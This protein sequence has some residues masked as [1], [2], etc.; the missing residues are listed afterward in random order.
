MRRL[1]GTRYRR[2]QIKH[3]TRTR[4]SITQYILTQWS[5]HP[6]SQNAK[7][8]KST[9]HNIT[10]ID[11]YAWLRD[12]DW[13]N[14]MQN[15]SALCANIRAYLEQENAYTKAFMQ[16]TETLQEELFEEMKNRIKQDDSTVPA[17][18]R[19]LLI[20]CTLWHRRR[21]SLLLSLPRA[22]HYKGTDFIKCKWISASPR[23]FWHGWLRTQSRPSLPCVQCRHQ[24][25]GVLHIIYTGSAKR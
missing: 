4:S 20:L 11:D 15:P 17:K 5:Y 8:A 23:I 6:R 9:L 13:Q 22:C 25:L 7:Q 10:R 16:D 12:P 19:R 3:K 14:V 1:L 18:G 2:G 21:A 24:R